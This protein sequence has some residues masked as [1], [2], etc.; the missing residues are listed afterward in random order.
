MNQQIN[1]GI[2]CLL[3]S[4]GEEFDT[5]KRIEVQAKACG[6][7]VYP[8]RMRNG[9]NIKGAL[10]IAGFAREN[11]VDIIHCHGYKANILMGVL[12]RRIRKIPYIVTIHGWTSSKSIEKMVAYEWLDALIANRADCVVAVSEM[13]TRKWKVRI[14]GL[15]P[16]VINNGIPCLDFIGGEKSIIKRLNEAGGGHDN[17]FLGSVGRL[18]REKGFDLLISAVAGVVNK[19]HKISLALLGDG[20]ERS[21][22][23]RQV[24]ALCLQGKVHFLGYVPDAYKY[25]KYFNAFVM[26]SRTEGFPITLLEAM[27]AEVPVIATAV[28]GIP[29]M[30]GGGEF[31]RLVPPEDVSSIICSI[32]E[33]ISS[34]ET[35][36][37]R[38]KRAKTRV[39]ENY[40]VN[41]MEKK[42][43]KC[44]KSILKRK[45]C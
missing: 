40:S 19:G 4:I 36:L 21:S 2:E 14:A 7:P 9:L 42:Y 39:H 11:R 43:M 44:Y 22:L 13:I 32:E 25:L 41:I 10:A 17:F 6:L 1:S 16:V 5:E 38:A 31:G 34:R 12:P 29:E 28:G 45:H 37:A 35:S 8:F 26:S 30:L 23:E 15:K 18:S 3:G 27:Q 24:E 33:A 20:E